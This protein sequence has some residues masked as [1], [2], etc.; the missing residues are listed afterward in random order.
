V[1]FQ[2]IGEH[3]VPEQMVSRLMQVKHVAREKRASSWRL[4]DKLLERQGHF[5]QRSVPGIAV[6]ESESFAHSEHCTIG[7]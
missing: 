3:G 5:S 1:I 2:I 4:S 7:R 6:R